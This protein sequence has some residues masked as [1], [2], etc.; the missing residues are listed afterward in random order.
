MH[1]LLLSHP[2]KPFK[3]L[4]FHL[5]PHT[6]SH[7]SI[8]CVLCARIGAGCLGCD[9]ELDKVSALNEQCFDL[10]WIYS[11]RILGDSEKAHQGCQKIEV[12]FEV[13]G[14]VSNFLYLVGVQYLQRSSKM[15]L[16]ILYQAYLEVIVQW[17]S[18]V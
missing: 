5:F 17:L 16:R 3:S 14:L 10:R 4:V 11:P 13:Y 12:W 6:F 9:S 2:R 7:I 18:R 15:R 1:L 8:R